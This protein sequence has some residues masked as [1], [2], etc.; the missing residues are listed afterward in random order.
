[1]LWGWMPAGAVSGASDVPIVVYTTRGLPPLRNV[2][3]ATQIRV[4]DAVDA[5]LHRLKFSY[6][7][8]P[9]TARAH[10]LTALDSEA[11]QALVP[12][13]KHSA[14][15]IALAWQHGITRLPAVL[16][17]N[18]YVVYGDYDVHRALRRVARYRDAR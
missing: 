17:D 14:Q 16:V 18:A 4:L 15:S 9:A 3:V 8:D 10:A 2:D 12:Q 5:S 1:M 13:L 7:G 6:P 11:G